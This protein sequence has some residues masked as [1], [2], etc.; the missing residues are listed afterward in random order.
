VLDPRISYQGLPQDA[1]DND[2]AL[3][4]LE[5]AKDQLKD[6]FRLYTSQLHTQFRHLHLD[7][8]FV[9]LLMPMEVHRRSTSRLDMSGF[10]MLLTSWENTFANHLKISRPATRSSGGVHVFHN[11][12]ISRNSLAIF[13]L[14][15]ALQL[16]LSASFLV[17][18]IPLASSV[19]A[20]L[21]Q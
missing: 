9:Q 18:V 19:L 1:A 16:Q 20:Y 12:R 4:H 3:R 11:F 10:T 17:A 6:H 8:Q 5:W 2:E 7:H 15:L 14:S 13:S 21:L